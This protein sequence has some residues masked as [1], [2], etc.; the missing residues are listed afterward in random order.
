MPANNLDTSNRDSPQSFV[1]S[2]LLREEDWVVETTP[3]DLQLNSESRVCVKK[4]TS[5][6][7]VC[8]SLL[9]PHSVALTPVSPVS[10]PKTEP[11]EHEKEALLKIIS[12]VYLLYR[13]REPVSWLQWNQLAKT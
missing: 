11:S 1:I 6:L 12:F 2:K 13:E 8:P 4:L 9:S 3:T 7:G 10:I 5:F